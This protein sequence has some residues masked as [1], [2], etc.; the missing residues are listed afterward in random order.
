MHQLPVPRS[1][2]MF[3]DPHALLTSQ[4]DYCNMLYMKRTLK[5]IWKLQLVQNASKAASVTLLFCRLH[6]L[7][8]YFWVQ[9][10]PF[11]A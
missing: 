9:L 6:W 3:T 2:A 8:A 5:N 1:E 7:L 10:K 4:L 11:M